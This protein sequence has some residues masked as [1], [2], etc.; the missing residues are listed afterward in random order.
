METMKLIEAMEKNG[1]TLSE[2]NAKIAIKEAMKIETN[3]NEVEHTANVGFGAELVSQT[4]SDKIIEMGTQYSRLLPLLKGRHPDGLFGVAVQILGQVG[5]LKGVSEVVASPMANTVGTHKL[6]TGKL[7][8]SQGSFEII[9]PLSRQILNYS[10]ANLEAY[11]NAEIGRATGETIDAL[12]LNADNATG[13]SN[14]NGADGAFEGAYLQQPKGLRK[15]AIAQGAIEDLGVISWNNI[16][17][18]RKKIKGTNNGELIMVMDENTY[19]EI[20][21]LEEYKNNSQ[22]GKTSTINGVEYE[23]ILG[24]PTLIMERFPATDSNGKVDTATPANNT[25]GGIVLF[26]QSAI[27]YCFGQNPRID[28]EEVLNRGVNIGATVDFGFSFANKLAGD[29]KNRVVY[30]LFDL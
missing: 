1:I 12:I 2:D 14:I 20:G 13:G 24:I 8:I 4:T 28:K 10:D 23:T 15:E 25:K 22:N 18:T 11:I 26:E 27:Q 9:I 29:T 21:K 3:T 5:L 30:S 16:V 19:Y 17:D 7:I 6:P